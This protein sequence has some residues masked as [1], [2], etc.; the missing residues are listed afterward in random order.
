MK[1][2]AYIKKSVKDRRTSSEFAKEKAL[3]E[4]KPRHPTNQSEIDHWLQTH[5]L[6]SLLSIEKDENKGKSRT[7]VVTDSK[8]VQ[9]NV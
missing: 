7:A 8:G 9:V 6:R 2:N 4:R 3:N 1:Q 5:R